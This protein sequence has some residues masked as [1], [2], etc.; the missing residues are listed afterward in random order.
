MCTYTL[1]LF[2]NETQVTQRSRCLYRFG[3]EVFLALTPIFQDF[4]PKLKAHIFPRIQKLLHKDDILIHNLEDEARHPVLFKHD[5]I[6]QHSLL[7]IN[8]T[9]YD[10]RRSQDVVNPS[11]SHCDVMLLASL[12]HD[13]STIIH[14]FCYARVLGVYHV[15]AVYMGPGMLDYEAHRVEFLWVRWFQSMEP[16][17]SSLWK[18]CRLERVRLS[19]TGDNDSF[20]FIDPSDVLRGSHILPRVAKGR[21]H[22]DG[23]GFSKCALDSTDWAEYYIGR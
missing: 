9:T 8:Y 14:P 17:S 1:A 10:V 12:D 21:L 20:G 3:G 15:N 22:K 23:K 18:S 2:Y 4:L 11:T 19:P 13:D 16:P 6:Y 7:R 5:R